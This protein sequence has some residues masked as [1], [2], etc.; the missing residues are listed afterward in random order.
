MTEL[1]VDQILFRLGQVAELYHRLVLV[2]A[3]AGQGKTTSLQVVAERTGALYLNINL[4]LS[5]RMLDL[6]ERQRRL[7]VPRLLEQVLAKSE[8]DT[9]LLDNLEILFEK[10]LQLDPLRLLEHLSRNR[11]IVAA[12]NGSVENEHI[13]YAVLGHPEH[14]RYAASDLSIVG[15]KITE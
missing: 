12:W 7:A 8:K 10:S 15:P 6:T 4:E 1:L 3:P 13:I 11:T 5:S 2:V 14:R 9:V